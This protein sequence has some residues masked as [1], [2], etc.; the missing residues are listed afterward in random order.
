MTG[1]RDPRQPRRQ[2]P[3]S[4]LIGITGPIGCGKSTVGRMLAELGGTVIDAD[5]LARKATEPGRS[6]LAPIRERFGDGVFDDSGNLD[7]A[8]MAQIVFQDV[9]ALADLE[10]IVHPEV[11]VLVEEALAKATE[12]DVPFVV[13]EAI[14]LVEGGLAQRCDEV[15]LI[16]C[17]P[18]TQRARLIARGD[19]EAD[20]KRRIETQGGDFVSRLE[21]KLTEAIGNHSPRVRNLATDGSLEEVRERVEDLLAEALLSEN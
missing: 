11:R 2:P 7:R 8:A 1:S 14:K 4:L 3:P 15:W 10:K 16:E 20:A 9:A 13:I 19:S 17:Q 21:G 5:V 18:D 12:D 6:T